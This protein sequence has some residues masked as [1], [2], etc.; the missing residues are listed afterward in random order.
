MKRCRK[1]Y[2][3]DPDTGKCTKNKRVVAKVDCRKAKVKLVMGE[4]KRGILKTHN[5]TVKNVKQA[6][7]IALSIAKRAC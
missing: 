4:F 5:V 1:P 3:K 7:A 6:I 2:V